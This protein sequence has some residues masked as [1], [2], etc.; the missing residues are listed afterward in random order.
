MDKNDNP[1]F[2]AKA[3]ETEPRV[4]QADVNLSA[5][6][7]FAHDV[8]YISGSV[9]EGFGNSASDVD[10]YVLTE[11]YPKLPEG[12]KF[13]YTNQEYGYY[14]EVIV[15]HYAYLADIRDMVN[16]GRYDISAYNFIEYMELYYRCAI[17]IPLI[18][19][20]KFSR[21]TNS[22]SKQTA[23]KA[24]SA[25]HKAKCIDDLKRIK[26]LLTSQMEL[27]LLTYAR[28]AISHA[29]DC[30]LAKNGEGYESKKFR[31]LKLERLCGVN[32]DMYRKCWNLYF[33]RSI[34]AL[35]L[36]KA[37]ID[38]ADKLGIIADKTN[39]TDINFQL[40]GTISMIELAKQYAVLNGQIVYTLSPDSQEVLSS[41]GQGISSLSEICA[42]ISFTKD[43]NT[44]LSVLANLTRAGII[45]IS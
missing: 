4:M 6:M 38:F 5:V 16:T 1:I 29:I 3:I 42:T 24:Y 8:A 12:I 35:E 30:W 45:K 43:R 37:A 15:Y 39:E 28:S 2:N 17:G 10:L 9:V 31:F 11:M 13:G 44:I 27:E 25:Y 20:G 23:C 41:I 33:N 36:A 14:N 26:I 18:N 22:F 7:N 21:I 19:E 40:T 32:S 34:G